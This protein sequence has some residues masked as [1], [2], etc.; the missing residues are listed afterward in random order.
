[1]YFTAL[2]IT[3][4][5]IEMNQLTRIRALE[6]LDAAY[7]EEVQKIED[8]YRMSLKT[9]EKAMEKFILKHI[10]S[11]ANLDDRKCD[12]WVSLVNGGPAKDWVMDRDIYEAM[13][14]YERWDLE[15]DQFDDE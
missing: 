13:I 6:K 8:A 14:C 1:M 10:T 2:L 3:K 15:D 11:K 7:E 4:K 9:Y 5:E 12:A